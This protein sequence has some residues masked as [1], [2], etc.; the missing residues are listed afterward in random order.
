M[1][2]N[3]NQSLTNYSSLTFCKH[4]RSLY[5]NPLINKNN[6]TCSTVNSNNTYTNPNFYHLKQSVQYNKLLIEQEAKN[7]IDEYL[8]RNINMEWIALHNPQNLSMNS[9]NREGCI[10]T[11][12]FNDIGTTMAASNHNH[13]IEIWDMQKRKLIKT[14]R[15]HKEIVT[16]LEYFHGNDSNMMLS[17]SLD[18]TIKVWRDYSNIDT[19]LDHS[20]WVRC[21]SISKNNRNFLSGCV[22]SVIKLW[23]LNEKKVLTSISNP[24]VDPDMLN[25]VNSLQFMNNDDNI[26]LCGLRNGTVKIF[27]KRVDYNYG[28][29]K[30]F[31]A[32]KNKLNS[33]KFNS[34]DLYLLSSGRDSVARLWD[35]RN[36]PVIF[37]FY[38]FI[39]T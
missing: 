23:D 38:S 24:N 36:L 20:D 27:D 17:C 10:F 39:K 14:I 22:S 21:I 13:H 30:Q 34:N 32:H 12:A 9:L 6:S 35:F 8:I 3:I 25:T 2:S 15:D 28:I 7:L 1:E 26:F 37:Y 31:K 33:I 18:K 16:G 4:L 11:M 29:I 5:L 19:F